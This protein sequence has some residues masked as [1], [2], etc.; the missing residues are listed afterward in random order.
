M[1]TET[2][3]DI[4]ELAVQNELEAYEFYSGVAQKVSDQSLKQIFSELAGEEY[5]HR[6]LL[7]GFLDNPSKPL[8]FKA[9]ADY[10]VAESVA[11]PPLRKDMKPA[12]AIALAMKKEEEAMEAYQVFAKISD[13]PEQSKVFQALA[14]MEKGHKVKLENLY[15][16][17][18]F[19]EVW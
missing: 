15:T 12:D 5:Q 4:M 11:L 3:R 6:L 17:M 10:K 19:P 8:R 7:Q 18:A 16:T 13:D 14:E 1:N 2:F 9:G